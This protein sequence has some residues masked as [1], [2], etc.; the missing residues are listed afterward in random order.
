MT[1]FIFELS[2]GCEWPIL[3]KVLTSSMTIT[4]RI[5]DLLKVQV[6]AITEKAS[7]KQTVPAHSFSR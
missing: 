6:V 3:E 2:F 7:H 5:G 1:V 4:E